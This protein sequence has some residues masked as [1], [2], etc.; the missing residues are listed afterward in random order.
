MCKKGLPWE[1]DESS[2]KRKS[3][4]STSHTTVV[5]R[6]PQPTKMSPAQSKKRQPP[7]PEKEVVEDQDPADGGEEVED[8]RTPPEPAGAL[9]PSKVDF[10]EER[11]Q[12]DPE[13]IRCSSCGRSF[14]PDR[15]EK[16]EKIC[17]KPVK[18]KRP[19]YNATKARLEADALQTF[20]QAAKVEQPAKPKKSGKWKAEHEY[21]LRNI[22][23]AKG[24]EG[25][26]GGDGEE[27]A[28][29]A[30]PPP[31][32]S[33]VQCPHWSV[34]IPTAIWGE[35]RLTTQFITVVEGSA[36]LQ[37]NDTFRSVRN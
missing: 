6:A 30:A 35:G 14:A 37:P 11:P 36:S 5:A 28:A 10:G 33:L 31:D 12:E 22:R 13:L 20:Q 4:G 15:I 21:F 8:V 34:H 23:A 26:K 7:P 17:S 27:E 24:A 1:E 16:H 9:F 19:A 29:A 3:A 18:K 25:G 32:P 2:P